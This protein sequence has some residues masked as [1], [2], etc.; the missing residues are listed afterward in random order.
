VVKPVMPH[1]PVNPISILPT[2]PA[3][4]TPTPSPTPTP[5]PTPNP[6]NPNSPGPLPANV[7]APLQ[8]IYE[9]FVNSGGSGSFTPTGVSTLVVINGTSVGVMI[10]ANNP[11]DFAGLVAQLQSDGLQVTASDPTTGNV[12]G[13]LPIANLPTIAQLPQAP[14]VLPMFKP[15]L[16]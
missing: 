16:M 2:S 15:I 10:H 12:E 1:R 4:T 5:T 7:S 11:G 9:Q 3:P 6:G 14:S 13:M 8:S